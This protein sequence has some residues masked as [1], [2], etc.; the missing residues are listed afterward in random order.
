MLSS[1]KNFRKMFVFH[2]DFPEPEI[3]IWLELKNKLAVVSNAGK[4]VTL[5][6]YLI[7]NSRKFTSQFACG[8]IKS[9]STF[10]TR[11]VQVARAQM[12]TGR[13]GDSF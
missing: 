5:E 10:S 13:K 11:L 3:R 12:I 4:P 2:G 1:I 7:Q 6:C 8:S 9:L